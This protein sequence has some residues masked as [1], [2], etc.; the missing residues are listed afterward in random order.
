MLWVF[1]G[2]VVIEAAVMHGLLAFWFPTAALILSA[3][4]LATLLWL[5][6]LI[7]S[8]K[9]LPVVIG[10]GVLLWRCG[11]R[12]SVAIP[13]DRIAGLRAAWD[14]ALVKDRATLNCALVAWPNIVI[15]LTPPIDLGG[16]PISRLAHKLDDPD[17]FIAALNRLRTAP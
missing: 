15:D 14:N 6:A 5:V 12:R 10:D 2:L 1:T 9:R 17:A 11:T 16:R 3:L 7:R 8:F 4:S 13:L